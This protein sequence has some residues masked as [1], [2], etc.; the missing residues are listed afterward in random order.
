MFSQPIDPSIVNSVSSSVDSMGTQVSDTISN[1]G[2][3]LESPVASGTSTIWV[4]LTG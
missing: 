4:R 2:T 1:I 3:S